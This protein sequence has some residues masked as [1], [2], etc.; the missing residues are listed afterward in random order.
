LAREEGIDAL[1]GIDPSE[2]INQLGTKVFV[3][4]IKESLYNVNL[5]KSYPSHEKN[6]STSF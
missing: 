2:I 5:T 6:N 3:T 1:T 4:K